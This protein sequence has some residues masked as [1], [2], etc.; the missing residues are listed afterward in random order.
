MHGGRGLWVVLVFSFRVRTM[1]GRDTEIEE[2]S[3]TLFEMTVSFWGT[4]GARRNCGP[5]RKAGPTKANA[6]TTK[7]PIRSLLRA[8]PAGAK[9]KLQKRRS[10]VRRLHKTES[11]T[12]RRDCADMGRSM[13]RPYEEG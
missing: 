8:G 5:P 2:G 13:L 6:Q 1:G 4:A 9:A 11:E 12:R 3:L 10:K 7:A